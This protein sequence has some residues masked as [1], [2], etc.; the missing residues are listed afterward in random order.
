MDPSKVGLTTKASILAEA[1]AIA[2]YHFADQ[3]V[4]A[5]E[6]A[7]QGEFS[8]TVEV[9]MRDG[10]HYIIQLRTQPVHEENAHQAYSILGTLVPVPILVTHKSSPVPYAYI[11]P[12]IP[13]STWLTKDVKGWPAEKHIKVAG[14]IG[15]MIGRCGGHQNSECDTIDKF[16]IPRLELYLRWGEP[17]VAP[18]KGLIKSLLERVDNLRKLPMCWTHW[19]INMMN[20]MVSNDAKVCGILDWE[21]AYWMP[22]GANTYVISELAA[23]NKRGVLSKRP[24]SDGMEFAFWR[25]LFHAAPRKVRDLIIEIQLAKDI[26]LIMRTLNDASQPPHSSQIGVINASMMYRVPKDLSCLVRKLACV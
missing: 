23:E 12:R 21:E 25:S 1:K 11:M 22:F 18:V 24:C 7:L 9:I 5:K 17:S 4:S 13:G 8:R 19:D 3:P 14:Q 16:I 15:D 20:I 10:A 2:A 26:G 6:C